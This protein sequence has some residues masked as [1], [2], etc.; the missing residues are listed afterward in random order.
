MSRYALIGVEGNH[1]QAFL[2]KILCKLLGFSKLGD[3]QIEQDLF[4]RRFIPKYPPKSLNL[5]KRLDM[6]TILY[7]DDLLVGIY[8][9]EGSKLIQNLNDKLS[10]ISD[11]CSSLSAFA[12]VADADKN[13]PKQVATTYYNGLKEYFPNFPNQVTIMGSV[14]KTQPKLGIYILPDNAN[15]G[16][17]DT[18]LCACGEVVYPEYMKRAKNYINQFSQTETEKLGWKPF[19]QEKATIAT[20]VSVLKP[21]KTNTVSIADNAWVSPQTKD[22]IPEL[23][24]LSHFLEELL[25]LNKN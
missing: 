20:V 24:N 22:Q 5:Y 16:V 3:Q 15:Q 4:W 19:D 21:G 13:T 9:G 23:R 1:D 14:T 17:L 6:P 8:A 18:L 2:E 11:F 7:K 12:I 25:D 10:N